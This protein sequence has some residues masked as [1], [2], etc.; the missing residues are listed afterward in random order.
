MKWSDRRRLKREESAHEYE[1]QE[2]LVNDV[3]SVL[4]D[5]V[6]ERYGI[7]VNDDTRLLGVLTECALAEEVG[8]MHAP[9]AIQERIARR[10]YL[11]AR[12]NGYS[13]LNE[14]DLPRQLRPIYNRA[15]AIVQ[16][17]GRGGILSRLFNGS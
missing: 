8:F 15:M 13:S 3:T 2:G 1:Q 14:A 16:Q 6:E 9:P 4:Q 17:N 7:P 11:A 12:G 10:L 5:L